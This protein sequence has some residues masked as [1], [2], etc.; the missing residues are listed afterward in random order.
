MQLF[1]T[2][3]R[4][5]VRQAAVLPKDLRQGT[6]VIGLRAMKAGTTWLS[7]YLRGNPDFFH[8]P[9]NEM[10]IFNDLYDNPSKSLDRGDNRYRLYRMEEIILDS[11]SWT[12]PRR[13]DQ[14]RAFAQLGR[15][16]SVDDYLAY[17]AERMGNETH[18]GEIS[19]AYFHLSPKALREIARITADVR[20]LFLMRDPVKRAASHIRHMRRRVSTN[21]PIADLVA[22]VTPDNY[23]YLRSNYGYTFDA[24]EKAGLLDRTKFL[25][26]ETLFRDDTMRDLCQWLGIEF[27][28]PRP[29]RIRNEGRGEDRTPEQLDELRSRLNPIYVD[30]RAR[31]MVATAPEWWWDARPAVTV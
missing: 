23:V 2:F 13:L 27:H 22:G 25:Y 15:I 8:S 20:F 5:P 4:R 24:V 10:N 1:K 19:P 30:L 3:L 26:Y 11:G 21:V 12:N 29:D 6:L 31:G 9:V 18:F 14:L 17:F 7:D 28:R 16:K